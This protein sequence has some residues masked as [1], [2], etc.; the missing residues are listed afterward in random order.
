MIYLLCCAV[1]FFGYVL[2]ALMSEGKKAEEF[3]ERKGKGEEE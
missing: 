1:F 2:G 3:V